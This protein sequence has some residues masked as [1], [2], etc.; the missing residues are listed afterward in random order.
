MNFL[1]LPYSGKVGQEI[2]F[3]ATTSDFA[4]DTLIFKLEFW[5]WRNYY[6]KFSFSNSRIQCHWHFPLDFNRHWRKPNRK[7]LNPS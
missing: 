1:N 4:T 7:H 6:N 2:E 3:S 5:R